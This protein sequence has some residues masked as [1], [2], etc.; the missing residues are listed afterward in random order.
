MSIVFEVK[1]LLVF[2]EMLLINWNWL[3]KPNGLACELGPAIPIQTVYFT[4]GFYLWLTDEVTQ[5]L[6]KWACSATGK[7]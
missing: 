6:K 1:I 3:T 5:T 4:F 2:I 7:H